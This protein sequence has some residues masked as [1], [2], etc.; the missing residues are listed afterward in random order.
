MNKNTQVILSRKITIQRHP[1]MATLIVGRQRKD[2]LTLL[3]KFMNDPKDFSTRIRSYLEREG[4]WK[5]EL[6][7]KGKAFLSTSTYPTKE[8]GLYHIWYVIDDEIIGTRPIAIQRDGG[9][10]EPKITHYLSGLGAQ[11]SKFCV[12]EDCSVKQLEYNFRSVKEYAHILH[13]LKPTEIGRYEEKATL[14]LRWKIE[15]E[16]SIVHITGALKFRDF[17]KDKKK[18]YFTCNVDITLPKSEKDTKA[19]LQ[20]IIAFGDWDNDVKR[21]QVPIEGRTDKE[22]KIFIK[23]SWK[24]KNRRTR[25]FGVF[26]DVHLKNIPLKPK[27]NEGKYWM[28]KWLLS[29]YRSS[30]RKERKAI[31]DLKQ[32]LSHDAIREFHLSIPTK[33]DVI[34]ICQKNNE[35]MIFWNVAAP[36]DLCPFEKKLRQQNFTLLRNQSINKEEFFVRLLGR[37]DLLRIIYSDRYALGN[38]LALEAI[39]SKKECMIDVFSTKP[40]EK[41]ESKLWNIQYMERNSDNHDRY[42][43][44]RTLKRDFFWKQSCSINY[45][46]CHDECITADGNATFTPISRKDLPEYLKKHIRNLEVESN[47]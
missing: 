16:K 6:T 9:F 29:Y 1:V 40:K 12:D 36:F 45:L 20:D 18:K 23:E 7:P 46:K 19:I 31:A 26:D 42:W 33:E 34:D 32:W 30:Y 21:V 41:Q 5:D 44:F 14:N 43:I 22:I 24:D 8:K 37:N 25:N 38:A 39:L 15:H 3:H 17:S 28:E 47:L 2:M 35:K 27:S 4:V 13:S 10:K 11:R